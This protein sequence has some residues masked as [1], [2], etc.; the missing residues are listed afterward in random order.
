MVLRGALNVVA[1]VGLTL[2]AALAAAWVRGS[3]VSDTITRHW[4]QDDAAGLVEREAGLV[5]SNGTAGL[6]F[7]ATGTS[8]DLRQVERRR[9]MARRGWE[10]DRRPWKRWGEEKKGVLVHLRAEGNS[11]PTDGGEL[12]GRTVVRAGA[13][14]WLLMVP[15]AA[16]AVVAWMV[17]RGR[18]GMRGRWGRVATAVPLA[19]A[20]LTLALWAA[21]YGVGA[22]WR[23][24]VIDVDEGATCRLDSVSMARGEVVATRVNR[25]V[26]VEREID[27]RMFGGRSMTRQW[28]VAFA[29]KTGWPAADPATAR[30]V[31]TWGFGYETGTNRLRSGSIRTSALRAPLWATSAALLPAAAWSAWRIARRGASR[32]ACGAVTAGSVG[33]TC[34]RAAT[35]APNVVRCQSL[36]RRRRDSV[37]LAG[38]VIPGTV[39]LE[40]PRYRRHGCRRSDIC[41]RPQQRRR[42]LRRADPMGGVCPRLRHLDPC[43][44]TLGTLCGDPSDR[45]CRDKPAPSERRLWCRPGQHPAR[46]RGTVG[47]GRTRP[48]VARG[49]RGCGHSS[50]RRREGRWGTVVDLCRVRSDREKKH[51]N[52]PRG[53]SVRAVRCAT[54][55]TP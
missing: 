3:F 34:A 48:P 42:V 50:S 9:R 47:S 43:S 16:A 40:G 17:R 44:E 20:G 51:L 46:G 41:H 8:G 37:A 31:T 54:W 26:A 2:C 19:A 12:P 5:L 4:V 35:A 23:R 38:G 10:W 49:R 33:M 32:P 13:P 28:D 24:Q 27:P 36:R 53:T 11:F 6:V 14:L 18:V 15:C 52:V 29:V 1:V 22:T 21:S 7:E 25:R 39:L 30:P 55:H 45:S